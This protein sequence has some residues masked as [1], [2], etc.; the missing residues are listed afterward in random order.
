MFVY[1]PDEA[2]IASTN[3]GMFASS[4]GITVKELYD[5]ADSDPEWFW[6]QVIKDTGI[7][8]FS[9]YKKVF[10]N[11]GGP[12][13]TKW[14]TEGLINIEYNAVSRYKDSSKPAVIYQN[15]YL[16]RETLSY[17]G[18]NIYVSSVAST[19]LD[20]GIR[21]GDRVGIYMPFNLKSAIAFY[22]ILRI[23]AVAVPMFSGYGY[24][25]V[26]TRVE[27]AGVKLLFTS[28]GYSRKGKFVDMMSVAEKVGLPIIAEGG[29]K[30]GYSFEDAMHGQKRIET[31]KTGSEDTAIMLYTSGTTGKPKGTVHVH[32]GALINIAKEVKYYM[33]LKDGDVLHWITDLGWMMGPWALI[34]TNVLHGTIYLY[35]G[36]VDYPDASRLFT[37]L[38]DNN[39]TLLGLSPTLVRM[40]RYKNI[41]RRFNTVR[42]FGS[43][44]E[45]WD[46]ESWSYLFNVLGG[47]KTP[48]SNISGGTDIIGCFLASNPAI[49]IKPKCLYRGLGMNA[50]IFDENGKEVYGKVG[51]LVAKK[52]SPSMTRG[53]WMAED[54]Y[55]ESYWSRF[56]GVWF[57][58]D[59]GEMD[60]DGYFYLYGRADDVIKVAG[61][62]VG[63]NELED[64]VMAVN[65]VIEAAV[66]SIPDKIKGEALAVFY[67]GEPDLSGRIKDA[68]ESKMGKPFSP[69]Y[70]LRLRKLPKTRNGKTMRRVIRSSF[71]GQDPGDL[72]NTEDLDSIKEIEE[73]GRTIFNND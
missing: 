18:L 42:L 22:S 62:R 56:Q 10:D 49:P 64:I 2:E 68:I 5:K 52:P 13:H 32:G 70:V 71:L 14:F 46:D 47:G 66:I 4:V 41:E 1:K 53:L 28:K 40:L 54:R 69:S 48:I 44:G 45:P 17:S 58:G 11:S 27:D 6:P 29:S 73:L 35:D 50:S 15:E 16:E 72:S 3:L 20:M 26:K 34:G 36:A 30:K 23:G 7:E 43:T 25:A 12:Q 55:L 33:D 67:V 57:H 37:I 59:F 8:F 63:P 61:K 39:V 31:E 19:L 60:E 21:K 9:P 38:E 51:Y 65:G 24:E